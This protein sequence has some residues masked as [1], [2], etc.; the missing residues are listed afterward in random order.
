MVVNLLDQRKAGPK[1]GGETNFDTTPEPSFCFEKEKKK[2][3]FI[4]INAQYCSI[5]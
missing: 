4:Y 5:I 1:K 2:S 3:S